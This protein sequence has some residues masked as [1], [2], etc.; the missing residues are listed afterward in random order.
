MHLLF[1]EETTTSNVSNEKSSLTRLSTGEMPLLPLCVTLS[2]RLLGSNSLGNLC[3]PPAVPHLGSLVVLCRS[4]SRLPPRA[5]NKDD[6]DPIPTFRYQETSGVHVV[7]GT[8]CRRQVLGTSTQSDV[9][10]QDSATV[11]RQDFPFVYLI[12]FLDPP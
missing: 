6:R 7:G 1:S 9:G 5:I 4:T 12:L 2:A 11:R 8:H 3:C 10:A